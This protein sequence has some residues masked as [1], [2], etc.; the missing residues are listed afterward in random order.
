MTTASM[1]L[2]GGFGF[3]TVPGLQMRVMKYAHSAAALAS[4]VNI[5][6]FNVGNRPRRLAGRRDHHRRAGLHLADLGRRRHH[7]AGPGG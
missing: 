7:R 6:A 1:V 5:G 3:A 4:G 2:L